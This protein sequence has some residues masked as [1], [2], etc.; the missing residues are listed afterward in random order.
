VGE[1]RIDDLARVAGTTVRSLRV[2]QDRRLMPPPELRGRRGYYGEHHVARVR[3]VL[4]LQERGYT[5]ATI[6]ELLT[7]WESGRDL[8]DLLGLAAAPSRPRSRDTSERYTLDDLRKRF[9]RQL[10]PAAIR[11]A[12]S[13]GLLRPD[14][15]AFRTSS[16]RLVDA[17]AELVA[18][19]APLELVLDLT[20]PLERELC[21]AAERMTRTVGD[22][23]SGAPAEGRAA[24]QGQ[25]AAQGRAV[26]EG[27]AA[28]QAQPAAA[29][30]PTADRIAAVA[31]T[32]DRLSV[33]TRNALEE[34]VADYLSA[35]ADT[36]QRTGGPAAAG[37]PVAG[38]GL[39]QK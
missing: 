5:L 2:L 20:G 26:A 6:R 31:A 37:S 4:R 33:A 28:V 18:A 22:H 10:T 27:R 16:P 38:A 29:G 23:L 12:V 8:G 36:L 3:L 15:A 32:V 21:A 1:Y 13:V 24:A 14:G 19:G 34:T 25:P 39:A 9:G 30:R 17:G 7:A 11:R 35:L